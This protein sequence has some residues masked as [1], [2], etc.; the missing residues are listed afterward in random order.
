MRTLIIIAAFAIVGCA[1]M[2]S[3]EELEATAEVTGDWSNVERYERAMAR[4][5]TRNGRMCPTGQISICESYIGSERCQ[6][7]GSDR[8]SAVL[9]SR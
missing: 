3:L 7:S 6:C 9:I 1:P 4:R 5:A 2:P 8:M